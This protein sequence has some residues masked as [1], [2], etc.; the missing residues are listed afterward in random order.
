MR[1]GIFAGMRLV[2]LV[3]TVLG[4]GCAS[5]P[6]P[7][8]VELESSSSA[9]QPTSNVEPAPTVFALEVDQNR[10]TCSAND[11]CQT[12]HSCDCQS[13]IVSRRMH[14][15]ACEKECAPDPCSGKSAQCHNG[16]CTTQ[17]HA[18]KATRAAAVFMAD[19]ERAGQLVLDSDRVAP[20]FHE[21]ERPERVPLVVAWE[22][23]VPHPKWTKFGKDVEVVDGIPVTAPVLVPLR[24]EL[25]ATSASM[26]LWYEPEGATFHAQ[27]AKQDG[28]WK[29]VSLEVTER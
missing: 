18:A 24:I 15:E 8:V 12:L 2:L 29:I 4:F 21:Q 14:V 23:G 7:D 22:P 13:C 6:R 17:G 9:G 20:Y 27:L 1:V 19:L 26:T 5:D 28:N 10:R 11:D 3:A 25:D 16:L